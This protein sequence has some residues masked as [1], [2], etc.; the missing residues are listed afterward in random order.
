MISARVFTFS[1]PWGAYT[2]RASLVQ[3][4]AQ[5]LSLDRARDKVVWG[6]KSLWR[7]C[8]EKRRIKSSSSSFPSRSGADRTFGSAPSGPILEK[9]SLETPDSPTATS[10]A[11]GESRA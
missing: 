4:W 5:N 2:G 8:Y 3:A 7:D 6:K 10:L 9:A 11:V 1:L